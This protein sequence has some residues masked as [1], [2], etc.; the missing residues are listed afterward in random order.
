MTKSINNNIAI[1][2]K[3]ANGSSITITNDEGKQ[4]TVG[5][6]SEYKVARPF[7][8]HGNWFNIKWSGVVNNKLPIFEGVDIFYDNKGIRK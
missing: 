1:Y 5:I 7:N 6:V 2:S 3:Y 4:D 8:I